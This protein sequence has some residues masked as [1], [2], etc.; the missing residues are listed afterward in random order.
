MDNPGRYDGVRSLGPDF[1]LLVHSHWRWDL[2][3]RRSQQILARLAKRHPV[4]FVEEPDFAAAGT[5]GCLDLREVH[6]NVLRVTP[7]LPAHCRHAVDATRLRVRALLQNF[8]AA[9]GGERRCVQ[10][11][12]TPQ[13]APVMLGHFNEVGVVYDCTADLSR[14]DA[15][16]AEWAQREAHLLRAADVVLTSGH[17]LHRTKAQQHPNTHY[18]GCGVDAT[19]FY[20]ARL[21]DTA[22]PADIDFIRGPILGYCGIIDERLDYDLL[23]RLA[24]A[25]PDWS[26]VMIGPLVGVEP[27]MLPQLENLY[28]LGPRGY[29]ELPAYIKAFDVCLMPYALTAATEHLNPAEALEYLAAGKPVISTAL[30]EVI[31]EFAP[32]VQVAHGHGEFVHLAREALQRPDPERLA[33]GLARAQA[34]SWH[35]VIQQVQQRLYTALGTKLTAA[36]G[37]QAWPG[38]GVAWEETAGICPPSSLAPATEPAG[39]LRQ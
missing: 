23:Q 7:Q 13:P 4:L 17:Q 3:E 5:S 25:R 26:V 33:A 6:P 24:Q 8:W 10:W 21:P 34:A 15:G 35:A 39:R 12:C 20:A 2:G 1:T 9:A 22:L 16:P 30:P 11:F 37:A 32:V 14:L 28:W 36:M 19:H 29:D 38:T 31:R 27:A 18:C